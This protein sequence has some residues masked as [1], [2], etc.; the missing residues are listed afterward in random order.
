MEVSR[1]HVWSAFQAIDGAFSLCL[2]VV[3]E[4]RQLSGLCLVKALVL[5]T[6][7]LPQILITHHFLVLLHGGFSVVLWVLRAHKYVDHRSEKIDLD[8][9]LW[10]VAIMGWDSWD[11][12]SIYFVFRR[13]INQW[14]GGWTMIGRILLCSPKSHP[15]VYTQLLSSGVGGTKY[16]DWLLLHD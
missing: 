6:R 13:N 7:V 2:S 10:I 5:F 12:R 16:Y 15:W 9:R 11:G 4:A 3:R 14:A 1:F 8:F